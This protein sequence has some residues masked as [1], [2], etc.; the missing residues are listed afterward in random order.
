MHSVHEDI[1]F[2]SITQ[3]NYSSDVS[4]Y[5]QL[6][7]AR[8]FLAGRM[9]ARRRASAST[10]A[11]NLFKHRSRRQPYHTQSSRTVGSGIEFVLTDVEQEPPSSRSTHIDS[12]VTDL[13][14]QDL[15]DIFQP[16]RRDP[17]T[18]GFTSDED[19]DNCAQ[20]RNSIAHN[21]VLLLRREGQRQLPTTHHGADCPPVSTS[22]SKVSTK[23]K[24]EDSW[25]NYDDPLEQAL[26]TPYDAPASIIEIQSTLDP[27]LGLPIEVSRE[28]K[29]LI[30]FCE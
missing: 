20:D 8:S 11:S 10:V 29:T 5:E 21:N 12:L 2:L 4:K 22:M 25:H 15:A 6:S 1:I 24:S 13:S 27:L 14:L 3:Q 9:H 28:E 26:R 30:Q 19:Y 18:A 23:I 7:N 16:P 17:P